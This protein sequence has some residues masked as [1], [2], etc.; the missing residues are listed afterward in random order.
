[1]GGE[2]RERDMGREGRVY[3]SQG[4]GQT[5]VL[6]TVSSGTVCVHKPVHGRFGGE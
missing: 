4:K 3:E 2:G 6:E 1:M 5:S